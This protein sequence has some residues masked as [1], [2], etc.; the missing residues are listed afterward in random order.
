LGFLER[1]F[2]QHPELPAFM[3]RLA[4]FWLTGLTDPPYLSVLY[5]I[6]A[7]GK[8][9]FASAL[10]HAMGEYAGGA[11]PGLLMARYGE[12]HPTELAFLQGMR[13]VVS[14]ESGEGGRLDEERIKALT[15]SD[16]ITARRMREDFYTFIPTH[17]FALMTNHKPIV[18]G[19]DEGIWRR[20]LLI[21]FAEVIPVEE[22]DLLL[23]EKLR[24]EASGILAW[25]VQGARQFF[26]DGG[27]ALPTVITDATAVYRTESDILGA[28]LAEECVIE[29]TAS[30]LSSALYLA[31]ENWC[32]DS[33]ERALPKRTLGLRLQERG[34]VPGKDRKS[35]RLWKGLRLLDASAAKHR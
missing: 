5:G 22:R 3:Q 35:Q 32:T 26:V 4:G 19:V 18:R 8:S 28:F 10:S 1:I 23:S 15:G 6:G 21:P 9:T 7:N 29:A 30:V 25:A 2:R 13:L 11:P 27:L 17:S 14:A 16:P 12:R 20:L 31:Y 33:G 34:F 24:T